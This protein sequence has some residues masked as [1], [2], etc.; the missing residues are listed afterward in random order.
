MAVGLTGEG[1]GSVAF[2]RNGESCRLRR[3]DRREDAAAIL[4]RRS[5]HAGPALA[6][7]AH[8][9]DAV[10]RDTGR[11][12]L[13]DRRLGETSRDADDAGGDQRTRHGLHAAAPDD[14]RAGSAGRRRPCR[15]HRRSA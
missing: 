3:G 11:S 1:F 2:T 9:G 7:A 5:A 4:V 12:G 6:D 10:A 15:C 13:A 14:A 8:A